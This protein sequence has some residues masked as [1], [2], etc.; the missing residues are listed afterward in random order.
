MNA[1]RAKAACFISLLRHV[2][3]CKL[4]QTQIYYLTLNQSVDS[5]LWYQNK[6]ERKVLYLIAKYYQFLLRL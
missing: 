5:L 1:L 2:H 4:L 3:R 6:V